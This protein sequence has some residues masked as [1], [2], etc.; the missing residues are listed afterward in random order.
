MFPPFSFIT[1]CL[2]DHGIYP[3]YCIAHYIKKSRL[4]R[5]VDSIKIEKWSLETTEVSLNSRTRTPKLQ[6]IW[7][8]PF[9]LRSFYMLH[10]LIQVFRKVPFLQTVSGPYSFVSKNAVDCLRA[11]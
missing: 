10:F 9:R 11:F 4:T 7:F 1:L 2:L 6:A 3:P 5:L 8:F